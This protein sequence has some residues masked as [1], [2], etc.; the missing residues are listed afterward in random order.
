VGETVYSPKL[1]ELPMRT[2]LGTHEESMNRKPGK[3]EKRLLRSRNQEIRK[4]AYGRSR[5]D[6]SG[7]TT[8]EE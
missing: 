4:T 5:F 3:Q 2:N 8:P 6:W 7:I 1:S